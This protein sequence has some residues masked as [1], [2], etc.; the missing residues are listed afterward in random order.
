MS[1]DFCRHGSSNECVVKISDMIIIKVIKTWLNEVCSLGLITWKDSL[2]CLKSRGANGIKEL[3]KL[4]ME[5]K[6]TAEM[7]AN[8]TR[9]VKAAE[10]P[11]K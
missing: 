2:S 6:L 9:C 3:I 5:V 11:I 8:W 7:E 1:E 10:G 4:F